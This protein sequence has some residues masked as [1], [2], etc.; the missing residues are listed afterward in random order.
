M[1]AS[2][3]IWRVTLAGNTLIHSATKSATQLEGQ[4]ARTIPSITAAAGNGNTN[5]L[6]VTVDNGGTTSVAVSRLPDIDGHIR[7]DGSG[8]RAR[9]NLYAGGG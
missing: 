6:S 5:T 7:C 1:T 3:M 4:R 8:L 2:L 9:E